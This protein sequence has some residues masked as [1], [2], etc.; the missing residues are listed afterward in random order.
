MKF[1]EKEEAIYRGVQSNSVDV[2]DGN[3]IRRLWQVKGVMYVVQI[4]HSVS[5][6][7]ESIAED[8]QV[9]LNEFSSVFDIPKELPPSRAYDHNI[10]LMDPQQSV[11]A[12]PYR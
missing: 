3:T 7:E 8:S 6:E 9:L 5:T 2:V 1:W 11:C 10:P 4:G 12:R